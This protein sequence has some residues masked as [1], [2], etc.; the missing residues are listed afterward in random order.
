MNYIKAAE[1]LIKANKL[2]HIHRADQVRLHT[3]VKSS[4]HGAKS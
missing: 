3:D 4:E 2:V 1:I